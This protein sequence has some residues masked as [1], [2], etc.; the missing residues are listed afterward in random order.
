MNEAIWIRPSVRVGRIACRTRADSSASRP[1]SLSPEGGS[2]WNTSEKRRI[3]MIP[4]QKLGNDTPKSEH[5]ERNGDDERQRERAGGE[6]E[7]RA[8]AIED[9]R[10]DRVAGLE[11]ASEI[12]AV[13]R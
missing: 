5:A 3:S 4:S 2:R 7:R 9:Q 8:E 6:L 12:A 11:R 13:R 1:Y 10:G